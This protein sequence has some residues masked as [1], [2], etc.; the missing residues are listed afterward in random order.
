MQIFVI[1]LRIFLTLS[2]IDDLALYLTAWWRSSACCQ[3]YKQ[4]H[5]R[6]HE[7]FCHC[8]ED[9]CHVAAK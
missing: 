7:I 5:Q 8:T 6:D 4:T 9:L 1:K 3:K 2:Q